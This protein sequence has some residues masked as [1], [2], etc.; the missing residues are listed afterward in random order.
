MT[1]HMLRERVRGQHA[2]VTT[3]ELFF[4]LV[5]VFAIT[6][7]SHSLLAHLTLFGAFEAALLM[8]A[9]WWA[10]IYTT[11][12]TNWL[13]P[14]HPVVRSMLFVL[15]ALGL[16]VSTSLPGAFGERAIPF[17]VAYVILQAGR[18]LFMVW[19]SRANAALSHNFV[20]IS[21][22]FLFSGVFWIAGA[23]GPPD[24]RPGLWV[25]ALAVE[26][27]A[28]FVGFWTPGLGRSDTT[29]WN[30]EG[31]HIAERCGLFVIICLGES[32][33]VTG[34]TFS[35]HAWNGPTIGAAVAAV[36]AAI[37]MWW[38]YF[39][40]HAD[41]AARA[42]AESEDPGRIAR[43]AYTY[44]H[45][46]VVAGIIVTAAGDELVLA[47]PSGH[48]EAAAIGLILGG[49]ALFLAGGAWFKWAVFRTISRPRTSGLAMLG[50][51]VLAAPYLTPLTLSAAATAILV[52]IAA[53]ETF[54]LPPAL[55]RLH[56]H[57]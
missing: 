38:I 10:W 2:R 57:N 51:T 36:G 11:W 37:A 3:L 25:V 16:M 26:Y 30:V 32:I 21:C 33:L 46:P 56:E 19:A 52:V 54:T 17:A 18:S 27:L 7:L 14:D 44:A 47:H 31:A 48:V 8:L 53:W 5:F 45:I 4:D 12:I 28:A 49:P 41:A 9:V 13:D 22:W 34:A 29:D 39:N 1:R 50:A 23:L 35:Q 42:I 43:I 24:L 55:P 6:Q 40:A 15:M 20:R